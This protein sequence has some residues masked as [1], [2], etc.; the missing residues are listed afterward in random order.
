MDE[1][2]A[3]LDLPI[4]AQIADL[5]LELQ[6]TLSLTYIYIS[7]DLGLVARLAD[8]VTV[9]HRGQIVETVN[10]PELLARPQSVQASNLVSA[11]LK[12][13]GLRGQLRGELT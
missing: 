2:L 4:Q 7:H 11:A 3:G 5:L 9:L 12:L 1:A 6:A 13:S 10:T 8:R